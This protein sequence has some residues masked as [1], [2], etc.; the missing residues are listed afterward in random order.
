MSDLNRRE[1]V[2]ATAATFAL[3]VLG[4]N[5]F[6]DTTAAPLDV[7][8]PADFPKGAVSAKYASQG[9]LILHKEDRIYALSSTCTHK[10]ATVAVEN[11]VIKCN[12]HHSVFDD[13]VCA[14]LQAP[15]KRRC[16][17]LQ[18]PSTIRDISSSRNRKKFPPTIHP[19]LSNSRNLFFNYN[20]RPIRFG[21]LAGRNLANDPRIAAQIKFPRQFIKRRAAGC[22]NLVQ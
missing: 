10:G 13:A 12:R 8:T 4:P 5:L 6:A 19:H 9:V 7:G 2:K 16:R 11:G 1:F 20:R 3:V 14:D 22:R 21:I 17:I 15:R 18:L